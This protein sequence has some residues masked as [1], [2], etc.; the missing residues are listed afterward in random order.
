MPAILAIILVPWQHHVTRIRHLLSP[1]ADVADITLRHQAE[2]GRALSIDF[3]FTGGT[4]TAV[5]VYAPCVP[6]QR[7]AYFTHTLLPSLPA[8]RQLLVGGDFNCVAGQLD[9]LG[10]DNAV[11]GRTTDY[12][13]GLRNAETDQQL[14]YSHTPVPARLR[15]SSPHPRPLT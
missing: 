3:S 12:Y 11:L 10:P 6:A 15:A 7:A 9:V 13:D 4:F 8:D 5:S 1:A 14:L 2:D